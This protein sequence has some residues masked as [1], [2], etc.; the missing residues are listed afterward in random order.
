MKNYKTNLTVEMAYITPELAENFIK[1]NV[2]N[3]RID[4][5]NVHNLARQMRDGLFLE[6]GEALVFDKHGILKDGQHRLLAIIKSGKS[7]FIPIVRGVEPKVMATF[8]TGKNRSAGD[9]LEL[10][11]FKYANVLASAIASINKWTVRGSK[12]SYSRDN[13]KRN[14]LSN[15]QILDYC[16]DNYDWLLPIVTKCSSIIYKAGKPIVFSISELVLITYMIGGEIPEPEVYDFIKHICGAS[17]ELDT[18]PNYVYK[19]L[20]NAKINKEPLN[21]YWKLGMIL[22]SWNYFIDGNPAINYFTFKTTAE[23]PKINK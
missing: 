21:F 18:A 19:K 12:S 6:N 14:K 17:R 10:N 9:V 4:V 1:Y 20:S 16:M 22:K 15:Q 5:E 8:D 23:L 11:N 2:K 7:Y 3:R 13:K